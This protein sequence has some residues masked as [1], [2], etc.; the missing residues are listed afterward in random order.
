MNCKICYTNLLEGGGF[1]PF[2]Q[3]FLYMDRLMG[4]MLHIRQDYW[5]GSD[6]ELELN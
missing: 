1:L 6:L 5:L 2:V 4:G 3:Q